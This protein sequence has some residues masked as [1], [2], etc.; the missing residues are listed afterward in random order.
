V[1]SHCLIFI[2]YFLTWD[3]DILGKKEVKMIELQK[4]GSLGGG[5]GALQKLKH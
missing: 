4:I 3:G 5:G 2:F 1:A